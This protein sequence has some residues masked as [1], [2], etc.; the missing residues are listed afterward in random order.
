MWPT[1]FAYYH[2][3]LTVLR[4]T[5]FT[6]NSFVIRAGNEQAKESR[7]SSSGSMGIDAL[8]LFDKLETNARFRTLL[9]NQQELVRLKF[10]KDYVLPTDEFKALRP[11]EKE[12][13]ASFV[14][15]IKS[16]QPSWWEKILAVIPGP[17]PTA[18]PA[19]R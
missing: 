13:V 16:P 3:G 8:E 12:K 1:P 5:R 2:V 14:M 6:G 19:A 4:V 9:P 15:R 11:Q 18:P 10:L 7:F 17:A